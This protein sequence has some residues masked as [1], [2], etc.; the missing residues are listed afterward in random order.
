MAATNGP[1]TLIGT[2]GADVIA[3]LGGND[4]IRGGPTADA[5]RA[6]LV[7]SGFA[8]AVFA[9]A[10]PGDPD[11]LY[12]LTKDNGKIQRI[13]L[14]D[15]S[16]ST[17]LDI[18]DAV[19]SGGGERG[20]LG[21]A[22]HPDFADPT[23]PGYGRFYV[24]L[25][26]GGATP[27]DIEIREYKTNALG[28]P[29]LTHSV[30]TI[31]H[32]EF[33]N[34]NGGALAFGP[35]GYLYISVGDGGG[36]GDPHGNGQNTHVLLGKILRIDVNR[37]GFASDPNKFYA[38]PNDPTHAPPNPFADGVD[39]A[40]EVWAYGLRNPWRITFD[41]AT[42]DLYI[43]DVGQSRREEI[44]FQ[45]AGSAG[46]R[47]YGWSLAEG[48][49]GTPPPGA[50]PPI[51]DYGRDL[52]QVV[53]GGYVYHGPSKGFAGSYFF[54][55][56]GSG[57]L[58]TLKVANGV[59]TAVV[60]R[61]AQL[62]SPDASFGLISSFG[63]DSHQNLYAVSLSGNIFRLDAAAAADDLG[64]RLHGGPGNDT[65]YGGPGNDG[66]FG[67]ADNDT[68]NGGIGNDSLVG[69]TGSDKMLGGI[70]NDTYFVDSPGDQ[71]IEAV[72]QGIDRVISTISRT[73]AANTETLILSGTGNINGAGNALRNS[74]AGNSG[75]NAIN[76]AGGDDWLYGQA[77][78]DALT[79]GAGNDRLAGGPG[80]DTLTG[81]P[82]GD[83]FLFNTALNGSTNV[84]R[85][86]D[87]SVPEDVI[88]LDNAIFTR[89]TQTGVLSAAAFF[90]GPA[91]H[92]ADDRIIYNPSTG[93]LFY[94]S[95]GSGA[96][97]PV[98]FAT[99]A[100]N[101]MLTHADFGVY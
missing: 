12:V 67:D 89:L 21:L 45:A 35:D 71:V 52:G 10:A 100:H 9:V 17:F 13:D 92:D 33:A 5:I 15:H 78:N 11:G 31:D 37:D 3:G 95:D 90:A 96:A 25:T 101:L 75:N 6:T 49:F 61:T 20:V 60:D 56:F 7:G 62:S 80:L 55:D 86:V 36:G 54:I 82:G 65:I 1:D 59:A 91:A 72:G 32:Q 43:G 70:G 29:T 46:G 40:P 47:N 77:G 83:H 88:L 41:S 97:A 4:L 85:I 23:K 87:F 64:D 73:L 94:D 30:L 18:D 63:V 57:R 50:I 98:K 44:D 24:D 38:I 48:T 51:F 22:F 42:G 58:W 93:A 14:T 69:G 27:G 2:V 68:L 8:G 39:G 19:F 79:G 99:L 26:K 76:G 53:T 66:L 34:H 81:G 84:D 16:V 28:P 74:I